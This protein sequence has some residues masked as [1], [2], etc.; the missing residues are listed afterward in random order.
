LLEVRDYLD[1]ADEDDIREYYIAGILKNGDLAVQG[2]LAFKVGRKY[3]LAALGGKYDFENTVDE[4]YAELLQYKPGYIDEKWLNSY[5]KFM[6]SRKKSYLGAGSSALIFYWDSEKKRVKGILDIEDRQYYIPLPSGDGTR[7]YIKSK[8]YEKVSSVVSY[9]NY[10]DI[11]SM[12]R[13]PDYPI[14]HLRRLIV[15]GVEY[16][17]E[18]DK[19]KV[20]AYKDSM[21]EVKEWLEKR[22]KIDCIKIPSG[23]DKKD[24]YCK[25]RIVSGVLSSSDALFRH[26]EQYRMSLP[27]KSLVGYGDPKVRFDR[28]NKKI[29]FIKYEDE[30]LAMEYDVAGYYDYYKNKRRIKTEKIIARYFSERGI[31]LA[32][33]IPIGDI[34]EILVRTNY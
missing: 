18:K 3:Y 11:Y 17:P 25:I 34:E 30:P 9:N 27:E 24:L 1:N 32:S 2:I 8:I 15:L 20:W 26:L 31:F 13:R 22:K 16:Y 29:L 10:S 14:E 4:D 28:K 12:C 7:V 21:K 33:E 23:D 6:E 5:L 19:Y